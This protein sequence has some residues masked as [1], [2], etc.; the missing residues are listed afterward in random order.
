M[1]DEQTL[2]ANPAVLDDNETK[3]KGWYPSPESDQT[4]RSLYLIQKRTIRIPWLETFD[5]PENMVSCGRRE[6][7]I[8]APQSLA[9]MNGSLTLQAA[10]RMAAS[11]Q[12][13]STDV[14]RQVTQGFRDILQRDP[15]EDE[16]DSCKTFL[17]TRTLVE[18]CL[19][20]LN[21]NEFGFIE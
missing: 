13:E 9:L 1:L 11:I 19:V 5:L 17:A 12:N 10:E 8:V 4:V 20:L 2:A 6:S 21:T 15:R 16:R 7:S 18:L 14:E 3:T